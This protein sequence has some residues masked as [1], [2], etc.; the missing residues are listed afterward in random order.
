MCSKYEI[1][2][3]SCLLACFSK[4]QKSDKPFYTKKKKKMYRLYN[5]TVNNIVQLFLVENGSLLSLR[6]HYRYMRIPYMI[7]P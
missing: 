5:V 1:E 6:S 2:H 3:R 7:I 4:F